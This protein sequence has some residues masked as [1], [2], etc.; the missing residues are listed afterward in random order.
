LHLKF[1]CQSLT[2]YEFLPVEIAVALIVV[3]VVKMP[4]VVL[5]LAADTFVRVV[6]EDRATIKVTNE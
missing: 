6:L 4:V 5:L 1:Y 2:Q 3:V